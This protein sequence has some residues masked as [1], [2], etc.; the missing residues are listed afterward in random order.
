MA[1]FGGAASIFSFGVI[2][3]WISSST[4]LNGETLMNNRERT[5]VGEQVTIYQ[6]GK[7]KLWHADFCRNGSHSRKSLKTADKRVA[8]QRAI[9]LEANLASG[10]YQAPLP[11]FTFQQAAADWLACLATEDL[12]HSTLVKYRNVLIV[13]ALSLAGQ[14]ATKLGQF[15][16]SHFD[17]YRA[18]RKLKLHRK[19][20]YNHAVIVKSF[21]K[22]CKSRKLMQEN[23]IADFKLCKPP[24]QPKPGPSLQEFKLILGAVAEADRTA[25]TVLAFTGMRSGELQRLQVQDLDLVGNWLHV[26]SRAG[27]ETKTGYSRKV[28]IHQ[29]LRPM[30]EPLAR[31]PGQW[32]FSPEKGANKPT[33]KPPLNVKKLNERFLVAVRAVGLPAGRENG[34]TLHSLRHYFETVTVNANIPQRAVDLWLGHRSDTSM[35]AVYYNLSDQQSQDFM[36][37]VPFGTGRSAADADV[38]ED[39]DG[40]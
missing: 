16:A 25:I 8:M 23:P 22:W 28:P 29:R 2:A 32:L 36:K 15:T 18:E 9:Q 13:F 30:L 7:K 40:D 19:T 6:R 39:N 35:G 1:V 4:A 38:Q 24:L 34:F 33:T 12:A 3:P 5:P 11:S 21:I 31:H 20:L 14:G 26:V 17:R 27:L 10:T 37:M